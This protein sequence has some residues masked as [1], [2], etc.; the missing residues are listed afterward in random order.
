MRYLFA[1]LSVLMLTGVARADALDDAV[2]A[3]PGEIEEVRLVGSWTMDDRQGGYRVVIARAGED[4]SASRLFVQWLSVGDDGSV[5]LDHHQEIAELAELA[6]ELVDYH[7][8]SDS[9]GLSLFLDTF[10]AANDSSQT[11]ELFIFGPDDYQFGPA[12]N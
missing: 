3:I 5:Q 9:E 6:V 4:L 8:E 12:S 1:L 2:A 10:D 7:A 11:Y